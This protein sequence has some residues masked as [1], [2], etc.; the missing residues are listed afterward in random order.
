[1][2]IRMIVGAGGMVMAVSSFVW[3]YDYEQLGT[4]SAPLKHFRE[5]SPNYNDNYAQ[6]QLG[7][8]NR[9]DSRDDSRPEGHDI[10]DYNPYY[11]RQG[12][13]RPFDD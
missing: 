7:I 1:M 13:R 12:N 4:D 11:D 8:R 9:D 6:D 10:R 3:A 5:N 2:S